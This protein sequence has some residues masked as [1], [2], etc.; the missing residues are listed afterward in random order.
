MSL[1]GSFSRRYLNVLLSVAMLAGV[2]YF[3]HP[4][5]V[6]SD[7]RK[8][9]LETLLGALALVVVNQLAVVYR[10][11]RILKHFGFD[12]EW[13]AIFRA[14]ILGNVAALLVIPLMGHMIGRQAVL[15]HTGIS[16]V[17][18][19]MIVAYERI[20]VALVS[21]SMAIWGGIYL[22]GDDV[23]EQIADI[24]V[25][26]ILLVLFVVWSVGR[27]L[28]LRKF[29]LR[30]LGAVLAWRNAVH[31]LEML[32]LT[33]L[34]LGAM[35]SCF[36]LLFHIVAPNAE[37]LDL[38]AMAAIVSFGASIPISFGGWGLREITAVYVLG[39]VGVS[40]NAALSAAIFCGLLSIVG[41]FLL[42]GVAMLWTRGALWGVAAG[43]QRPV[44]LAVS[45]SW[46]N[47]RVSAWV[48]YMATAVLI[49]FQ[50]RVVVEQ[51][52][53]NLSLADPFAVLALSAVALDALS[54]KRLP[55]WVVP[56]L[57]LLLLL[58][59]GVFVLGLCASLWG[60]GEVSSWAVGKVIGW[61]ALLGYMAAGYMA[62]RYYGSLGFRRIVEIMALV[63][64]VVVVC[65]AVLAPIHGFGLPG[66]LHGIQTTGFE[67]YSGNRNAFAFQILVVM[68]LYFPLLGRIS[69]IRSGSWIKLH[70]FGVCVLG[71]LIGGIFLTASRSAFIAFTLM[72]FSVLALRIVDWRVVVVGMIAGVW[73][74][75]MAGWVPSLYNFVPEA[76]HPA[77]GSL[78]D[79]VG[80]FSYE[81]SDKGRM[82]LMM[83]SW[84]AWLRHPLMGG[85]LGSFLSD[86]MGVLG[87]ESII[88]NT[89]LWI[90]AEMGLIGALPFLVAFFLIVR[91]VW[92]RR[93]DVVRAQG[94]LLLMLVFAVMSLFHEV[95]YQRIF[96]LG[97]GALTATLPFVGGGVVRSTRFQLQSRA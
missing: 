67:A 44:N 31:V 82:E 92:R 8:F 13:A 71:I 50:V 16:P 18:N 56:G 77:S 79:A 76:L 97:L 60:R 42:A 52:A 81:V 3:V 61:V 1:R 7:M 57:N 25:V 33:V 94:L 39:L 74:W 43:G 83:A 54:K 40:A 86:S 15:R 37:L 95:L 34:S 63:L 36:A 85:G 70:G 51:T 89:L 80:R 90:M 30:H 6:L 78:P 73:V 58:M 32:A 17:E 46:A 20:L 11:Q 2:L 49:F 10:Y 12:I 55:Y 68:A 38:Y 88:H 23:F 72:I 28:G 27:R 45:A 29:E 35:L 87:F 64:C 96:W 75:V 66:F 91:S 26:E 93:V 59:W 19:A 84:D 47:E 24:P 22:L 62:V 48:L 69:K 21:A 5:D 41:I 65:A 14:S 4:A 9:P 53:V